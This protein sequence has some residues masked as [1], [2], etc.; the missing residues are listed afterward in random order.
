MTAASIV[1]A[2]TLAGLPS[3]GPSTSAGYDVSGSTPGANGGTTTSDGLQP[4]LVRSDD[5]VSDAT[6]RAI[7][8]GVLA[9]AVDPTVYRLGPGDELLLQLWGR[10][11]RIIVLPVDPEGS[12]LLPGAGPLSVA[13]RTLA[14]TRAELLGRMREQFHGVQMDLRLSRPRTFL[15]YLAGQVRQP[16]PTQANGASRVADVLT[17]DLLAEHASRRRIEVLH[18]DGRRDIA[19]LELFLRSG[20]ATLN[21][22]LEDGD[23][24]VVPVET[25]HASVLGAAARPDRYE[26]GVR[27]SLRT[28][29]RIA[30][31][32]L[33]DADGRILL[34]TWRDARGA[35]SLWTTVADVVSGRVNPAIDDGTHAYLFFVPEYRVQHQ[36][37]LYG[38]VARPGVYPILEGRTRLSDMVHAASG[39]LPTADLTSI[40]L[41]RRSLVAGDRDAELERLLRLS[42]GELTASEYEQLRTK[43]AGLRDDYRV[44][45]TRL[46][47]EPENQDLLLR[48][49]DIVR[50]ERLV[51][52]IRVDGEVRRPGILTYR[53]GQDVR[54]F[55]RQAGGFTNRAWRGKVRV[56]RAVTGQTLLATSVQSIDPGDFIWVPEKPDVTVWQQAQTLLTA[57]TS[58]ATIVIAIRS[59]R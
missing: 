23:V 1:L 12:V 5:A 3:A 15:V 30:G 17:R 31:G 45:W 25:Q 8:P 54:D 6:A 38:E 18:R 2:L 48:D 57:V 13:G 34:V 14:A 41:H 22:W 46:M 58:I 33:P 49:G 53:A 59:L 26:L 24:L 16:G 47:R 39:F 19:D 9:G 10:V 4:G 32:P 43:L 7:A 35:D 55:V 40:R 20:D 50:V 42:R 52:S 56:T 27:D 37:E 29:L 11:S 21:P 44:D 51:N 36:A 28:L